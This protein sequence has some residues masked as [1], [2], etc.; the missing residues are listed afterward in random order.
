[1]QFNQNDWKFEQYLTDLNFVQTV[2]MCIDY[3]PILQSRVIDDSL[4]DVDGLGPFLSWPN[5]RR[6]TLL[7][8]FVLF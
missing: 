4:V 7:F 1:M 5:W 6:N 3:V 8:I 2:A